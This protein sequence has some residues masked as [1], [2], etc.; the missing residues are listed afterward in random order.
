VRRTDRSSKGVLQQV[1]CL[2][3]REALVMRRPWPVRGC[4]AMGKNIMVNL[5]QLKIY[6]TNKLLCDCFVCEK[7][8]HLAIM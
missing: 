7:Y 3:D 5:K 6:T 1:M 8:I 4:C 2:S